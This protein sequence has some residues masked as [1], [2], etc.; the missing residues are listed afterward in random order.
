MLLVLV[1]VILVENLAAGA[2]PVRVYRWPNAAHRRG[3]PRSGTSHCYCSPAAPAV[4]S[5]H[6]AVQLCPSAPDDRA[7]VLLDPA[8]S[9]LPFLEARSSAS[10]SKVEFTVGTI[11]VLSVGS[12]A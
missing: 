4:R 10:V 5:D 6:N 2:P 3:S 8:S 11:G 9:W 1:G 12:A 7:L